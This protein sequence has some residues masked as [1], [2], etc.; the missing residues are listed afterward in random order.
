MCYSRGAG[1]KEQV[2]TTLFYTRDWKLAHMD[3]SRY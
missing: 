1:D 2:V 3:T